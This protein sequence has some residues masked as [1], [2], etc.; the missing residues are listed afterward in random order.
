MNCSL[1]NELAEQTWTANLNWNWIA[2]GNLGEEGESI[3]WTS[4][5]SMH[6]LLGSLVQPC[7]TI[8]VYV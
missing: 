6:T 3:E 1:L 2:V 7:D 8:Q 5:R 4:L